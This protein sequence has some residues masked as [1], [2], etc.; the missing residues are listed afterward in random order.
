MEGELEWLIIGE[1][2]ESEEAGISGAF[3]LAGETV[4]VCD[5]A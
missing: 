2:W 5:L 3:E 1:I 4:Q